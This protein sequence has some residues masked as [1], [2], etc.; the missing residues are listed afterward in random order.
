MKTFGMP[1]YTHFGDPKR[2]GPSPR[3]YS[4][5]EGLFVD[6]FSKNG[7]WQKSRPG[8]IHS[9]FCICTLAEGTMKL[10]SI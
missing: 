5:D 6:G 4:G 1:T 10:I 8:S 9:Q 7:I 2:K 3:T